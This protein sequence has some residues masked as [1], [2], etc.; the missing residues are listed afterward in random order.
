[1]QW[2]WK[3]ATVV[4][5]SVLVL[6][7]A[8]SERLPA[9]RLGTQEIMDRLMDAA[10][11]EDAAK[12]W[13]IVDAA[14]ERDGWIG[15]EGVSELLDKLIADRELDTFA[16]FLDEMRK[17]NGA[18]LDWQ[19]SDNQ[20]DDLVTD[21]ERGFLDA[22]L[23][24][25]LDLARL[26]NRGNLADEE[27]RQ[28]IDQRVEEVRREREKIEELVKASA[29]GDLEKMRELLDAGADIDGV[30]SNDW[31]PLTQAARKS[32]E[33]AVRL[34]LERGA[35]VD[36]ARHPGWDYTPLCLTRSVTI[37]E[38]L[39]EAGADVNARLWKRDTGILYYRR[40]LGRRRS[41]RVVPEKW[42]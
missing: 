39:K 29:N 15:E 13:E 34:L 27:M 19:P 36:K 40:A 32:Q 28:W 10:R 5:D 41:G 37:A 33:E 21:G 8:M 24:R 2:Q 17:T 9:E 42:C 12:L 26:A 11:A 30:A 3:A 14:R 6:S 16:M 18:A 22:L 4:M 31:T 25:K 20:L 7:M 35:Q 23:A 1:M 38:M